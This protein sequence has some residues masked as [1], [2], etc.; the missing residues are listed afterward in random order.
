MSGPLVAQ[1]R[2]RNGRLVVVLNPIKAGWG[3]KT[4]TANIRELMRAGYP[5]HQAVAISLRSA[6]AHY[7]QRY[8]RR[9]GYPDYLQAPRRKA[10]WMSEH[11]PKR[12]KKGVTRRR[13]PASPAELRRARREYERLHWRESPDEL[14]ETRCARVK[15]GE[16]LTELGTLEDLTYGT[17]KGGSDADW[18]HDFKDPK[19]RLAVNAAGELVICGGGYQVGTRG[20]VG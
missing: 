4:I 1:A 16:V 3:K 9:K 2:R 19:P 17:S 8:P 6:R 15:A 7:R 5:E 20:I 11:A 10:G 14:L 13:N 12:K 18:E